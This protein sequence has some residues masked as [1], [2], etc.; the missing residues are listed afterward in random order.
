MLD[1]FDFSQLYDQRF[2]HL[3][4]FELSDTCICCI[5]PYLLQNFLPMKQKKLHFV[6]VV[7][8]LLFDPD[9]LFLPLIVLQIVVNILDLPGDNIMLTIQNIE[10]IVLHVVS[11]VKQLLK[12]TTLC[13]L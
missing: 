9:S 6:V 2:D 5:S 1:N 11:K 7:L 8:L 4:F 12:Q 3:L 10:L 13:F